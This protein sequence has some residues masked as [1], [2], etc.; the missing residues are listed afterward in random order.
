MGLDAIRQALVTAVEAAKTSFTDYP[1]VI[2][3]TNNNKIDPQTQVNPYLIVDV[4]FMGGEQADLSDHPRHRWTGVLALQACAKQG[5]GTAK[6]NKVLDHFY[7]LLQ[8][9]SFSGVRTYLAD[10]G[11]TSEQLGWHQA[12][13]YIPFWCDQIT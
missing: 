1:L 3:Y 2:E 10:Y 12:S 11:R 6:L 5:Q 9:K 4:K 13:L 8:G 7:P